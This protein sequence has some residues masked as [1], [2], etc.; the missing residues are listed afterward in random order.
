MSATYDPAQGCPK[1][2]GQSGYEFTMTEEH[3]MG[4]LGAVAHIR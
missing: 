3:T 4:G 1:C 2:G